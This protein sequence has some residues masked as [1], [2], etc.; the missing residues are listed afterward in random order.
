MTVAVLPGSSDGSRSLYF[1]PN[2]SCNPDSCTTCT[3]FLF[4][5]SL[6]V[7]LKGL[8]LCILLIVAESTEEGAGLLNLL[9]QVLPK[10]FAIRA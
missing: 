6:N 3:F 7:L 9:C 8:D 1:D 10:D 4:P 2:Y 5:P